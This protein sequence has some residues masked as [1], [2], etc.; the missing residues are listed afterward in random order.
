MIDKN[1]AD[2]TIN[3]EHLIDLRKR[4]HDLALSG[5]S[6]ID[7]SAKRFHRWFITN[8]FT[9][10]LQV[11]IDTATAEQALEKLERGEVPNV[12]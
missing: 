5:D 6:S 11:A 12:D 10:F 3:L 2:L 7:D 9:V 4:F 1:S 8:V